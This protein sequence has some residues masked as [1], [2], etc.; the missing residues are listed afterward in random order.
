MFGFM[1]KT[2]RY[3]RF[4]FRAP[5]KSEHCS[6]NY[7]Q[8]LLYQNGFRPHSCRSLTGVRLATVF[9]GESYDFLNTI[10]PQ[11]TIRTD[12]RPQL[13]KEIVGKCG[14]IFPSPR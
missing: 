10:I 3:T 11:S 9:D 13:L 8:A 7:L 6:P 5:E 12:E 4:I 14:Y 2:S 1:A